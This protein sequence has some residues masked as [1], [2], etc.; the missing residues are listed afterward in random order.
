LR[1]AWAKNKTLISKSPNT[2]KKVGGVAQALEC[3]PTSR[4]P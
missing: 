1:P 2:Q 4:E 3:L